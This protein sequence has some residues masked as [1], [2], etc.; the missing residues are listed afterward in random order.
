MTKTTVIAAAILLAIAGSALAQHADHGAKSQP[1]QD[2]ISTRDYMAAAAKMHRDMT[3]T[4]SGDA[5]VDFVRGM[6]PHHQAAIDMA[7]VQLAHGKDPSV[8]KLAE[9]IIID[10]QEAEIASMRVWLK[11]RGQ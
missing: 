5:D 9:A 2:A 11:T 7:K 3:I 6:I 1:A 4:Y 8:R 10:A